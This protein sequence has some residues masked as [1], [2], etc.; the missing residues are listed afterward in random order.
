MICI[1]GSI[2]VL[3]LL[4]STYLSTINILT[5]FS[6]NKLCRLR[7][8]RGP[9]K[10]RATLQ[11]LSSRISKHRGVSDADDFGHILVQDAGP[12]RRVGSG[13]ESADFPS[14]QYQSPYLRGP[15]F[16]RSTRHSNAKVS[17]WI[18][19]IT[20][21]RK[22]DPQG[23]KNTKDFGGRWRSIFRGFLSHGRS[24]SRHRLVQC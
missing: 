9:V 23:M 20:F 19:L 22:N 8:L 24:Q 17:F 18:K 5:A 21:Q 7:L 10:H 14:L 1:I 3:S 4:L 13:C 11:E 15:Q 2:A 6:Q 16:T 12:G